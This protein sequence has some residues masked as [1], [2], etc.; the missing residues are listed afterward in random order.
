VAARKAGLEDETLETRFTRVGEVPFS[1]ARKMMSTI[2]TDAGTMDVLLVKPRDHGTLK[3][4][5]HSLPDAHPWFA[6][7]PCCRYRR[8]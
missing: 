2:H 1:S 3:L 4:W 8:P 5:W 6:R 7:C